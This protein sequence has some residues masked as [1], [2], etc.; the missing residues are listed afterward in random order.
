MALAISIVTVSMNTVDTIETTIMSISS[1]NYSPVE[2]VV[3]DGASADG[4]LEVIRNHHIKIAKHISEPDRGIY[5]AMNKGIALA[6][7]E[8][9]GFLNAG[10]VYANNG[11]LQNVATVMEDREVDACYGDLVYVNQNDTDR[12]TR[13]WKSRPYEAGLWRSG[14]M[15]AH[16]TFFARR[17][18][19]ERAGGFD[20][21]FPRQADFEMAVRLFEI[22][23]IRSRYIP[24]VMV[25]MRTGGISN[26]SVIGIIKGNIEA[27]RACKKHKLPVSPFFIPRKIMSRIPQFLHR[28]SSA[29]N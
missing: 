27:Y 2:H 9:I 13:Y 22:H 3:V 8:V 10:D 21:A 12:V 11:V 15:P 28:Q 19:Y 18:V 23:R 7:G 20:L 24:E 4:T 17:S 5:D 26:N 6:T 1:Q 29:R 25:R 16:P 14:W